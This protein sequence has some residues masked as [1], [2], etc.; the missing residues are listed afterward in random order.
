MSKQVVEYIDVDN[1]QVG[2]HA[3][4]VPTNHPSDLVSN[5]N[6]ARTSEVL[7]FDK[8]TGIFET[9]NT[10]YKPKLLLG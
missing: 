5:H 1:V 3:W 6:T 7:S 2:H 9:K 10:I 8:N 4:V